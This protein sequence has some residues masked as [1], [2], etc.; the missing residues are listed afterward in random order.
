[1]AAARPNAIQPEISNEHAPTAGKPHTKAVAAVSL[2]FVVAFVAAI[3][4]DIEYPTALAV[5]YAVLPVVG[6]SAA[7]VS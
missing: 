5:S 2:F 1:V 3:L 4:T 6:K 7:C